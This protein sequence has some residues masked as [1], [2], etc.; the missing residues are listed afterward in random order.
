MTDQKLT[1]MVTFMGEQGGNRVE[2]RRG[3]NEIPT[4]TFSFGFSF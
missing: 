3:E 1:K 2:E 4:Y